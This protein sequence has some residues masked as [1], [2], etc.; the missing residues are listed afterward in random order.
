MTVDS[1]AGTGPFGA[2]VT[3]V[4]IAGGFCSSVSEYTPSGATKVASFSITFVDIRYS[5][6]ARNKPSM[7]PTTRSFFTPATLSRARINILSCNHAQHSRP[8]STEAAQGPPP[9]GG[10][11]P[12]VATSRFLKSTRES[13]LHTHGI[14]WVDEVTL[15]PQD[16][17]SSGRET[18]KMN[19]FQA[20]RD[21]MR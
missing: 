20:I 6:G 13:S 17:L 15:G 21:A 5:P 8:Q 11:L 19:M 16:V 2:G 18:R 7:P 4:S 10:H 3:G 12:S 14:R 9:A 1:L